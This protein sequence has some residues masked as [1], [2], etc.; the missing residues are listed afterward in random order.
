METTLPSSSPG[1]DDDKFV[2]ELVKLISLIFGI[3]GVL[4]NGLVLVVILRVR[5]LWSI[6]NL[7]IA[8]QSLIDLTSSVFLLILKY[9]PNEADFSGWSN[10]F[11]AVLACYFWESD[12]IYWAL[13]TCST[14]NLILLTMER[15][16]AVVFPI[17]YR[18]RV[19]WKNAILIA[20]LPWIISFTF[21][22]FWP[23]VF[24]FEDEKCII[25]YRNDTIK[26]V[27]GVGVFL[28]KYV[29]PICIMFFVY[30][31]IWMKIRPQIGAS[32][33]RVANGQP[34]EIDSQ[35]SRIR[36]NVLKTLFLVS[37]TYIVCWTPNQIIFFRFHLGWPLDFQSAYYFTS[38]TLAFCNIWI[39][40]FI[41][42]FQYRKF[43]DGLRRLF[44][45][46]ANNSRST[47]VI[48]ILPQSSQRE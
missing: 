7:Y 15:Y 9:L 45:Y 16:V 6:T 8:N 28:V 35:R 42:A 29:I 47:T 10:T 30:W 14:L 39:N 1:K 43:Q 32:L 2:D 31:S 5:S 25:D 22:L 17:F 23:A 46:K 27:I 48:S 38:V 11:G 4:A 24:R 21:E 33:N 26:A 13:L 18:A 44:P 37:V 3:I 34:L 12:Y 36:I 20:T 19:R 41:Y 40:P